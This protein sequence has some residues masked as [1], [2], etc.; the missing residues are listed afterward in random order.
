MDEG[1]RAGLRGS[2]AIRFLFHDGED[3]DHRSGDMSFEQGDQVQPRA[4]PQVEIQQDDIRLQEAGLF[5]RY[6]PIH[7][8]ADHF[9]LFLKVQ[10]IAHRLEEMRAVVY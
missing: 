5:D 2:L 1:I 4:A 3:D 6:A 10:K 7:R 9:E 8:S